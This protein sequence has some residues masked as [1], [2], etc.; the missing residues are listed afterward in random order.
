MQ[1]VSTSQ[2][3]TIVDNSSKSLLFPLTLAE[4]I[5]GPGKEHWIQAWE[6]KMAKIADIKT[7]IPS[8]AEEKLSNLVKP[9][10]SKFTFQLTC[11]IDGSWKYKV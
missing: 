8:T 4:A 5:E 2:V 9:L 3:D 11:L 1:A 7:W 6:K 10:K